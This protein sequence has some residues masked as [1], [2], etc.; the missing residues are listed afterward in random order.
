[1]S[2]FSEGDLD[3]AVRD[4]LASDREI[5]PEWRDAAR[6]AFA[7]R[8]VDQELLAL[9][10]DSHRDAEVAVRGDADLRTLE[11]AGGGLTLEVELTGGR[12]LGQ[13]ASPVAGEVTV[14]WADGHTLTAAAD[15]SGFFSLEAEGRGPVRFAVRSG[16]ARLVTEWVVP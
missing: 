8:T 14:E 11:F 15:G 13:L 1:M 4:V 10:H 7:W 3:A 9:T 12:V 2:Q 5:P 6:A 16:D